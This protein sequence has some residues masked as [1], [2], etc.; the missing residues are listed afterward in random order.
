MDQRVSLQNPPNPTQGTAEMLVDNALKNPTKTD[1]A[2]EK[3]W[4]DHDL[5]LCWGWVQTTRHVAGSVARVAGTAS[6]TFNLK[7]FNAGEGPLLVDD[8]PKIWSMLIPWLGLHPLK[9]Y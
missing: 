3:T 6:A 5:F 7:G 8:C 4:L 2:S 1:F 9:I